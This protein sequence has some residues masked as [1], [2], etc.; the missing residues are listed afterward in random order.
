MLYCLQHKDGAIFKQKGP[1][2]K[3]KEF[4]VN[5]NSNTFQKKKMKILIKTLT[6]SIDPK[7]NLTFN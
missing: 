7:I 2:R 6:L 3:K 1:S 4:H 5:S